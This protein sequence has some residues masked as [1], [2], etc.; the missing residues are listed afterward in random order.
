V[1]NFDDDDLQLLGQDTEEF[2]QKHEES[3]A[4]KKVLQAWKDKWQVVIDAAWRYLD[5]CSDRPQTP[6]LADIAHGL[7]HLGHREDEIPIL[8]RC[9]RIDPEYSACWWELGNVETGLCRFENAKNDFQK[10]VDIGK[11]SA[12]SASLVEDAKHKRSVSR[13]LARLNC[14]VLAGF[15]HST[16]IKHP[17]QIP[18]PSILVVGFSSQRRATYLRTTT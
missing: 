17:W 10:V 2:I 12:A 18:K 14:F 5:E 4:I 11:L 13:F 7:R 6:A 16:G 1:V 3:E 8:R 15:A 9:L